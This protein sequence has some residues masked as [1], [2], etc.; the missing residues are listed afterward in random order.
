[1]GKFKK[2][3]KFFDLKPSENQKKF[4]LKTFGKKYGFRVPWILKCSSRF[5]IIYQY[6]A[7]E[8]PSDV[9]PP[10]PLPV[11]FLQILEEVSWI[12][13]YTTQM[14]N[15]LTWSTALPVVAKHAMIVYSYVLAHGRLLG[16]NLIYCL[17]F[18]SAT[19]PKYRQKWPFF[20]LFSKKKFRFF[21]LFQI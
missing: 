9:Q 17:S 4:W 5:G 16:G 3:C 15:R 18:G 11:I 20:G 8:Y 21:H 1:M 6:S 19:D 10:A 12:L 2:S 13:G 7:P 14:D